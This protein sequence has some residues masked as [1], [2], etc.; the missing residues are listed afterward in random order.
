[1]VL[2]CFNGNLNGHV[3]NGFLFIFW[4][5]DLDKTWKETFGVSGNHGKTGVSIL[6]NFLRVPPMFWKLRFCIVDFNCHLQCHFFSAKKLL[7]VW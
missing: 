4:K 6:F 7:M 3:L 5:Q 1:M 2:I